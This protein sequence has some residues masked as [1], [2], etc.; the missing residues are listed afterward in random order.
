MSQKQKCTICNYEI[1]KNDKRVASPDKKTI[2]CHKCIEIA[3]F[4]LNPLGSTANNMNSNNHILDMVRKENNNFLKPNNA[5][6][7]EDALSKQDF[8]DVYPHSIHEKLNDYIIGQE[9]TKKVISVAI[10]QHLTRIQ[11]L[12]DIEKENIDEELILKKSNILLVGDSG[13]GKTLFAETISKILNVPLV[14]ADASSLTSKGYVGGDVDDILQSLLNKSDN[15]VELA[16]RGIVF[17]DEIDK[18]SSN[19]SGNGKT[20]DVT[21]TGVQENLLKIIEGSVIQ[22]K[23]PRYNPMQGGSPTIELDTKNILFIFG[24]AF[25]GLNEIIDSYSNEKQAMGFQTANEDKEELPH[26]IVDYLLDYGFSPEFLGRI[27][28]ISKLDALTEENLLE[29]ILKPKNSILKQYKNFLNGSNISIEFSDEALKSIVN[30]IQ[31]N[32]IGARA[33]KKIFEG[34]FVDIIYHISEYKNNHILINEEFIKNKDVK[35]LQFTKK[36]EKIEDLPEFN[37]EMADIS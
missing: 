37:S 32:K 7:E 3:F 16:E 20:K 27:P 1:Q 10:Y 36:E 26:G 8:S 11:M 4:Q 9:M 14:I 2:I 17:I 5:V 29:I 22:L 12:E 31:N 21:G 19:Y 24:G 15:E 35:E 6:F 28:V 30:E 13:S 34:L 25:S 23:N 18:I 33:L